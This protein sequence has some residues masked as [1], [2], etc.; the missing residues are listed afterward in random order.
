MTIYAKAIWVDRLPMCAIAAHAGTRLMPISD[1]EA[2]FMAE[3]LGTTSHAIGAFI[4]VMEDLTDSDCRLRRFREGNMKKS[5][6]DL[7]WRIS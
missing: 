6:R 5:E 1:I 3:C 2:E 4:P 7:L